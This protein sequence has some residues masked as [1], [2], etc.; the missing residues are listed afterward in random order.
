MFNSL[1]SKPRFKVGNRI[2][3]FVPDQGLQFGTIESAIVH[4]GGVVNYC[5][6]W[7]DGE[8]GYGNCQM[9]FLADDPNSIMKQIV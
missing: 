2:G 1:K 5:V 9:C 3:V 7:D 8:K 6:N 4:E